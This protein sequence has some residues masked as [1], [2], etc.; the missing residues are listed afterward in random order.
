MSAAALLE[1]DHLSIR[2]ATPRGTVQAVRDVNLTI[3]RGEVIGLVGESGSGKSSLVSSMMALLPD[4]AAVDGRL[5]FEGTDIVALPETGRRQLR[6]NGIAAIFQDPF[7]ALNPVVTIGDLLVAVQHHDHGAGTREKRR[8]ATEMMARVGIS[9]AG[10]RLRQYPFELSGGMRQRVAIAAALLTHPTLL[11]AD[12]PTTALDATTEAQII[13][14]LRRNRS[15]VDGAI[16]FVTHHLGLVAQLCDRVAVMYAGEIVETGPVGAVFANP[17]HP[18]TRALIACEPAL[19]RAAT[20][21]LPTIGGAP[22]DLTAPPA[23]CGFAPRCPLAD[24][25]CRSLAPPVV[26]TGE[27]ATARCHKVLP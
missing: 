15:A 4:N 23:G 20:R 1:I 25:T 26:A 8:R 19:I 24:E 12:E 17:R 21:R 6:G 2:Y 5:R 10:R 9:D 14:L 22:P 13:D 27:N 7:T 18:Y 11:I 16:V 3:R